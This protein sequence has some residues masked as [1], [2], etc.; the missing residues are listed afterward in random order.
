MA[1]IN[2]AAEVLTGVDA[3]TLEQGIG[4]TIGI[5]F[6]TSELYACDWVYAA[7][8]AAGSDAVY[9]ASYSGRVVLVD[10]NGQGQRAYNIGSVP[11]QII[12]T[13]DYLYLL[14]DTRLYVL[15][16]NALCT[17]VDTFE[18]GTLVAAQT[19]FGLPPQEPI[20]LVSRRRPL[21]RQYPY[22]SSNSP[23]VLQ[24]RHHDSGN[25]PKAR[26]RTGCTHMVGLNRRVGSGCERVEELGR[27]KAV[28][29]RCVAVCL[30]T[31]HHRFVGVLV[32]AS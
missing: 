15:R 27:P 1:A 20:S 14:T 25:P 23:R 11:T 13:G 22:Q 12:D 3:T 16:D 26:N 29:K 7:S 31:G 5:Q 9:L 17:L 10:H 6:G 4:I 28:G 8:F 30:P 18:K 32:G 21:P 24:R 19:G 2:H